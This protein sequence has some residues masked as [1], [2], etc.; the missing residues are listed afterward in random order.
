M[1]KKSKHLIHSGAS[2][3]KVAKDLQ[4]L[5]DFQEE[6]LSP[7]TLE[8]L[9]SE[10]LIP[11]LM[12]YG[13]P[14]FHSMFNFF[15]EEGAE[16]GA[17]IALAYNQGVTNWQVSPGGAVLEELCCQALCRLFGLS[18]EADATFM[19]SGTYANQ[20]A[21]YLALHRKAEMCGFDFTQKGL[22]GFDDPK[23]LRVLASRD[24]HFSMKHA[25]RML[26]LGEESLVPV[27][28]DKNRRLDVECFKETVDKLKPAKDIF[29]VVA[30]AGTTSTGSVDP[31]L[32]IAEICKDLDTWLHV[33]GAYGLAYS[34]I[35]ELKYLFS[36]IERADS[37]SWDPHKQFGV[38]IP[39]SLL[40][41]KSKEDFGR[42]AIYSEYFNRKDDP[43][44]NPGLK[45]PP[46]TR[47]FMAL[48]LATSLRYLGMKKAV[49]RLKTPVTAIR[50]LAERLKNET[51]VEIAHKPDTGILCFRLVPEGFPEK[52]LNRLQ[53][54]I[55]ERIM[56]GGERTISITKL[57]AR[58]VLR[59]VAISPSVT[60]N[61]LMETISEARKQARDY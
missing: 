23:R 32:A 5:I 35:P 38:P 42:M 53:E 16:L 58:T 15:L 60:S 59:L 44:P 54:Q 28:V 24:A 56:S 55:Y 27:D 13:H 2:P 47:P 52:E 37:V 51:D 30:T 1:L 11:H 31:I 19:Y 46:S 14:G 61:E 29:C 20:E 7:K 41:V 34:L 26:G 4:P 25:V 3:D 17:K 39:S 57:D 49:K 33:D 48:S 18:P 43:R 9:I 21:L 10:R 8:K 50:E 45:S 12:Q 40:F 36:G 6:G 22:N